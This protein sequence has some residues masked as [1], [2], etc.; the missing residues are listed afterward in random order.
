L[1]VSILFG[2]GNPG[3][4]YR[5]TR[6]NLGQEALELFARRH[7]LTW[8]R[9]GGA[10]VFSRWNSAGSEITLLESLTYMND[11]GRA[12]E[13]YAGVDPRT[14]LVLCDD[15]SLPLGRLRIRAGG[16]SG[17]HL[18]LESVIASLGT[19]EFARMRLGIGSPPARIDWSEFVLMPFLE[20]ERKAATELIESAA[21]ALEKI[22]TGGLDRAMNEFNRPPPE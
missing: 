1:G 11:S 15:M 4:R 14:L 7:S 9:G 18:G 6:H 5:H 22:L 12:L 19:E 13:D 10:F 17:G 3:E 21:D 20:E 2:L 16:G 8:E